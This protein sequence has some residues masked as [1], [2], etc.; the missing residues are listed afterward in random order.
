MRLVV[1]MRPSASS[2]SSSSSRSISDRSVRVATQSDRVVVVVL[3]VVEGAKVHATVVDRRHGVSWEAVLGPQV[4]CVGLAVSGATIDQMSD[5]HALSSSGVMVM[6]DRCA[7]R[8]APSGS[9]SASG[10]PVPSCATC[11][12][13]Y[14]L[15]G[16]VSVGF[17]ALLPLPAWPRRVGNQP[18]LDSPFRGGPAPP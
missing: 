18:G 11:P 3:V 2:T 12:R 7:V 14:L 6:R 10:E 1:L 16:E 8:R 13:I 17:E 4:A 9:A 5:T 15:K